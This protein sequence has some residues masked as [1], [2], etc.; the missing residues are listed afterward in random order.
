MT[1]GASKDRRRGPSVLWPLSWP[2]PEP[3]VVPLVLL[4][5]LTASGYESEDRREERIGLGRA[6]RRGPPSGLLLGGDLA[7]SNSPVNRALVELL[8]D[9]EPGRAGQAKGMLGCCIPNTRFGPGLWSQRIWLRDMSGFWDYSG[10]S[11][12][13]REA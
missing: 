11:G 6:D 10:S 1:V 5:R 8:V 12:F 13:R 4:L 3:R 2:C 7:D 9:G